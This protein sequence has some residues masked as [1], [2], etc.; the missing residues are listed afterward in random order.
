MTGA[1]ISKFLYHH[2][3][4]N[5][6]GIMLI[7]GENIKIGGK[8]TYMSLDEEKKTPPVFVNYDAYTSYL[9]DYFYFDRENEILHIITKHNALVLHERVIPFSA[10]LSMSFTHRE[11]VNRGE[12]DRYTQL[13]DILERKFGSVNLNKYS[14]CYVEQTRD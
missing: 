1:E 5:L 3:L 2:K 7:N 12:N 8:Q 6:T 9:G 11:D 13:K 10:I 4:R 14:R